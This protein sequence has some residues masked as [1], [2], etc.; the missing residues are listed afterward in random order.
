MAGIEGTYSYI[1]S[2]QLQISPANFAD[3][4]PSGYTERIS[5]LSSVPY[6][7]EWEELFFS[8]DPLRLFRL[9][10]HDLHSFYLLVDHLDVHPEG[11]RRSRSFSAERFQN[12]I[13]SSSLPDPRG[14]VLPVGYTVGGGDYLSSLPV[15]AL[16][17]VLDY[18]DT[19]ALLCL[20]R[21][22]KLF[23]A[24]F[25]VQIQNIVTGLFR[26]FGLR[27]T[28]V[29]FMQTA[30]LSILAGSSVPYLMTSPFEMDNLDFF[31]PERTF[32]W[33]ARFFLLTTQ[34]NLYNREN[35]K[36]IRLMVSTTQSA[37]DCVSGSWFTPL[38]GAVTHVGL[39]HF[40]PD[41]TLAGLS[42]PN[43]NL[44]DLTDTPERKSALQHIHRYMRRGF[45]FH[46]DLPTPHH[47]GTRMSCPSTVRF[48]FDGGCFSVA[49][50][51]LAYAA[52]AGSA[53]YPIDDAV[54][55]SLQGLPCRFG[56]QASNAGRLVNIRVGALNFGWNF[57]FDN[58][59]VVA[60]ENISYAELDSQLATVS[61]DFETP[62]NRVIRIDI[63]GT[64][65]AFF[66]RIKPALVAGARR[67]LD[68]PIPA[69]HKTVTRT[70]KVTALANDVPGAAASDLLR[71]IR[72]RGI[73]RVHPPP[74]RTVLAQPGFREPRDVA[75][76]VEDLWVGPSG[77]PF[78]SGVAADDTCLI[79]LQ[80][81][82][83]P[84]FSACGH[85]HCYT[86]I[87]V[88]LEEQVYVVEKMLARL[89]GQWDT[90]R[91]DI[92]WSGLTFPVLP[93]P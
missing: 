31:V 49:F 64:L 85:G 59:V 26:S 86:C 6:G 28:H 20:S 71:R 68:T 53:L 76:T 18:C 21:L 80:L 62:E 70:P 14:G 8:L 52:T 12:A 48:T 92:E 83:H 1:L 30:T 24:L 33:V 23:R 42:L 69:S 81:M 35:K 88:W 41:T 15:D 46:R 17:C 60:L 38:Y 72:P 10:V 58:L 22:S 78:I 36:S 51:T 55:W 67:P 9:S 89:Y 11:R 40:C 75:L 27:Y 61:E 32:P 47:C 37:L 4:V 57:R 16:F 66:P 13:S 91:V 50:P 5:V 25:P 93:S 43:R 7:I 63:F 73:A 84:V 19:P 77:P 29:R 2:K 90:S 87:R 45:S 39:V 3:D 65:H 44:L 54:V 79:C 82:S 74:S 56:A 34:Y